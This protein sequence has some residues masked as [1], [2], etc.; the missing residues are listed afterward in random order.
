MICRVSVGVIQS[1]TIYS[2]LISAKLDNYMRT[3]RESKL[4]F[5]IMHLLCVCCAMAKT[6]ENF[7]PC[8]VIEFSKM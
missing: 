7:E 8:T 3:E 4:K 1:D 6:A 2:H 5:Y